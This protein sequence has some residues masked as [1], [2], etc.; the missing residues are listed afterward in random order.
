MLFALVNAIYG[1]CTVNQRQKIYISTTSVRIGFSTEWYI[2]INT[3]KKHFRMLHKL[4]NVRNRAAV[5]GWCSQCEKNNEIR[6]QRGKKK[7][8]FLLNRPLLFPNGTKSIDGSITIPCFDIDSN[9]THWIR[10]SPAIKEREFFLIWR[11]KNL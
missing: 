3:I 4:C 10:C 8:R 9:K 6:W 1:K 5:I 2:H 7:V 11:K